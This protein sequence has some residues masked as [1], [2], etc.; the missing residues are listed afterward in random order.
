M[1]KK[2][3][4]IENIIKVK[5]VEFAD[6]SISVPVGY[7]I[8]TKHTTITI[9]DC[10]VA[11]N[12][13]SAV[14][15]E[16]LDSPTNTIY[17]FADNTFEPITEKKEITIIAEIKPLVQKVGKKLV[18]NL[19]PGQTEAL[20]A[21]ERFILMLCGFQS[22]KTSFAPIWLMNEI[23]EH[24]QGDYLVVSA[25]FDLF[26]TKFLPELQNLFC[27]YL[28]Y[29]YNASTSMFVKSVYNSVTNDTEQIRIICRSADSSRGVESATA[30]AVVFDEA[31]MPEIKIDV[32]EA[33]QRRLALNEGRCLFTT[34]PYNLGWLKTSVY[35]KCVNPLET[36]YKLINF[37]STYN[38][39]FKQ[40]EYDRIWKEYPEWKAR[41]FLNGEFTRPASQIYDAFEPSL[42]EY[43]FENEVFKFKGKKNGHLLR[44]FTIP[45]HWKRYLGVDFGERNSC[46]IFLAEI[47]TY[48]GNYV[49]YN[50]LLGRG[51]LYDRVREYNEYFDLALGGASSEDGWRKEWAFNDV[52]VGKP[53]IQEVEAGITKVRTMIIKDRI[54]VFDTLNEVVE[55]LQ[56][57]SRVT[58]EAGNATDAIEDKNKYHRLDALRYIC[59]YLGNSVLNS[60]LE[61]EPK[62]I[63]REEQIDNYYN[64]L[65]PVGMQV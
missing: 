35:D 39:F 42:S 25:T 51:D 20:M 22:G 38:P 24:G 23:N 34:T 28:K 48:P 5:K 46:A 37:K 13:K 63:T 18:F 44:P 56:S 55:E 6:N 40:T 17:I 33:L 64:N 12:N 8:I 36:D 31:G 30:K 21:K 16:V 59:T 41:M 43:E 47:P 45:K 54:Y 11:K 26:N 29:T 9:S 53:F 27:K 15:L 61:E 4:I 52:V 57:Y 65:R 10:S 60:R 2:S 7:P 19:H 14:I 3:S 1:S 32:W 50:C 58:D 49:I 62:V